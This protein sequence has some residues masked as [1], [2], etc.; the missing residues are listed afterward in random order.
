MPGP[1][2][3]ECRSCYYYEYDW[4]EC[5]KKPPVFYSAANGFCGRFPETSGSKWC[6]EY[7]PKEEAPAK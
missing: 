7:R 5:R 6:G 1:Q 2:N 4:D 3:E